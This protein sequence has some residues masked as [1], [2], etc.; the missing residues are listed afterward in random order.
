MTRA[1]NRRER[2]S[3]QLCQRQDMGQCQDA[4][5]DVC[6]IVAA[7]STM[8]AWLVHIKRF[9]AQCQPSANVRL[10]A[11]VMDTLAES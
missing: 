8:C 6:L 5:N 7:F 9:A 10:K 2:L 4:E 11:K 3:F 1:A